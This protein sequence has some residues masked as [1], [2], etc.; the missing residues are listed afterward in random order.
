[1]ALCRKLDQRSNQPATG[2]IGSSPSWSAACS[3]FPN[4]PGELF[5]ELTQFGGE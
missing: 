5:Q 4:R 3:G 1:M 2:R